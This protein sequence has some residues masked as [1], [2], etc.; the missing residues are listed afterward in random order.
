MLYKFG[1]I[2]QS[3][4]IFLQHDAQGELKFLMKG[5]LS[6]TYFQGRNEFF[7]HFLKYAV[8]AEKVY[9]V[10]RCVFAGASRMQAL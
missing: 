9:Q 1:E 7:S 4:K 2:K 3:R 8:V 10:E 5:Y 6:L